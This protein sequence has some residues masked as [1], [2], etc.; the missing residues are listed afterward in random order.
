MVAE[1]KQAPAKN[2]QDFMDLVAES[3]AQNA[4]LFSLIRLQLLSGLTELKR[5]GATFSELKNG[6]GVTDGA[7]HAN[8][9]A[10]KDMGYVTSQQVK[11]ENKTAEAYQITPEGVAEWQRLRAFLRKLSNHG[12]ENP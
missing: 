2:S 8:L 9:K 3:K 12:G 11:I 7:L 5:D 4:D 10:L 6:L 1:A